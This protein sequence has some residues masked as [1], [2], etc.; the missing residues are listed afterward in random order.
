[1][2]ETG[3]RAAKRNEEKK[4]NIWGWILAVGIAVGIAL[5]VRAFLFEI[6]LV[7]GPSM[8]PTLYTNERL[9]VEKVSRYAGLP[10]RGD[11]VIVHYSDGTDNNYV[12][13]VIGLPGET[14]EVRNSTVY[15]NGE[16][17]A[18]DFV[19]AKP[20]EDMAPVTVPEDTI[21]VM[22]DNRANSTDSRI[23]G[24][25]RQDQIVGHAFAVLYPFDKMR[26]L[27]GD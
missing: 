1:M 8:E 4:K 17:L 12:K 22:G 20:Y 3:S 7:D 27:A 24:P 19:S 23:V 6:I 9:A 16:A 14:V 18:E 5:L 25:V 11:I 2:A 26:G 13:R 21:F 15:I 10:Q